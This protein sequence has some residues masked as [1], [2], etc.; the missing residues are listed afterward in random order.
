MLSKDLHT[1]SL[2][3]GEQLKMYPHHHSL[4]ASSNLI[5]SSC[6]PGSIGSLGSSF[7]L[8]SLLSLVLLLLLVHQNSREE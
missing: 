4:V 7:S 1:A 6:L 8:V 2:E 5:G 3:I